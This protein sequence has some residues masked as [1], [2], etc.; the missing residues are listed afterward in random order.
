MYFFVMLDKNEIPF[1][2]VWNSRVLK[3]LTLKKNNVMDKQ[4]VGLQALGLSEITF[5]TPK[6]LFNL[7]LGPLYVAV[8]RCLIERDGSKSLL[9]LYMDIHFFFHIKIPISLILGCR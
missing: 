8:M 6:A 2:N 9:L 4:E 1:V 3:V 5:I 7:K